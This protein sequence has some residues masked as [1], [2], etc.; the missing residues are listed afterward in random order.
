[1]GVAQGRELRSATEN[2][3]PG[4]VLLVNVLIDLDH[5]PIRRN[6]CPVKLIE[7]SAAPE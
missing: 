1:M 3:A 2:R 4:L 6:H 7:K 5:G